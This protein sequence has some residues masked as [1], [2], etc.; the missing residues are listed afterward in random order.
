M[1]KFITVAIL[2]WCVASLLNAQ[3]KLHSN[4]TVDVG[5]PTTPLIKA[6]PNGNGAIQIGHPHSTI[7][8]GNP[9]S[10]LIKVNP[11]NTID[12]GNNTQIKV[13]P[14][15]VN[16]GG[17]A[18]FTPFTNTI[19]IG[20]LNSIVNIGSTT[21]PQIKIHSD[22]A[23]QIGNTG[24]NLFDNET[25]FEV[26][27]PKTVIKTHSTNL[28]SLDFVG[29]QFFNS[30]DVIDS[31]GGYKDG[32]E[33]MALTGLN[34]AKASIGR[35]NNQIHRIYSVEYYLD[36]AN[37]GAKIGSDAR[38]KTNIRELPT[39]A[40]RV[41]SLR[42]V[43]YDFTRTS[44][45]ENVL[46]NPAYQNRV[47]FIAQEVKELFPD[48]VELGENELYSLDYAGLIPYLTKVIQE[49]NARIEKLERQID[50]AATFDIDMPNNAPQQAPATTMQT[51]TENNILFQNVPNPF[52]SVTTINYRLDDNVKNAKICIYNLTGKQ[53]QC[54]DLPKT[55][56]ENAVEVR[57]SSLQSGMYLYSLIVDGRLIDTKRM[58]LTD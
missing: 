40:E 17:L 42:P 53:L 50:F 24:T 5:N 51:P 1:K 33:V 28:N 37:L 47:G 29:F 6:N 19:Q 11:N 16:I 49:Q 57:A 27:V 26:N 56:G 38:L 48:L 55:K 36:G 20:Y 25:F 30:V 2:I 58:I 12:I 14:N 34:N 4:G 10:P 15:S 9:I 21:T 3:I 7:S 41:A 45:G 46:E 31:D 44:S 54:Y 23:V 52:N 32:I 18:T 13:N 8:I 39:I 22:G 35:W 43:M